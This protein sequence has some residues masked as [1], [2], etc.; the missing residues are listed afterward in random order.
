MASYPD[1]RRFCERVDLSRSAK[2]PRRGA[3]GVLDWAG[4]EWIMWRGR[5][6]GPLGGAN[7]LAPGGGSLG[8]AAEK[9]VWGAPFDLG[10]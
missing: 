5:V 7:V 3:V 10:T 1:C 4:R 9:G 6:R 2:R 8:L